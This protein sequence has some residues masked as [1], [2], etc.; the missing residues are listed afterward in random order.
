[1]T[2]VNPDPLVTTTPSGRHRSM[3]KEDT[4]PDEVLFPSLESGVSYGLEKASKSD[5][6]KQRV[7]E[8]NILPLY[9][10]LAASGLLVNSSDVQEVVS[11]I[12]TPTEVIIDQEQLTIPSVKGFRR[13][14]N[15]IDAF[16][17]IIEPTS[18]VILKIIDDVGMP[19]IEIKLK[20]RTDFKENRRYDR[21]SSLN[22]SG[23]EGLTGEPTDGGKSTIIKILPDNTLVIDNVNK[24]RSDEQDD[25][26]IGDVNFVSIDP[27]IKISSTIKQDPSDH[28]EQHL[29][30]TSVDYKYKTVNKTT[31]VY[32]TSADMMINNRTKTIPKTDNYSEIVFNNT[33]QKV[34][35]DSI[36]KESSKFS[37]VKNN[38][39]D[40][41]RHV[42]FNN[43]ST[44]TD[45]DR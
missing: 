22:M 25:Q 4:Y 32:S 12:L 14:V 7:D 11:P 30:M 2:T 27:T 1:M 9:R 45:T 36:L 23:T 5:I 6:L 13:S 8:D 10:H 41:M 28:K 15:D 33:H 39:Y 3:D 29:V 43:S 19:R 35:D 34:E 16:N 24:L 38:V 17:T 37:S 20:P 18:G 31:D 26:N 42:I 40:D 21:K 44:K